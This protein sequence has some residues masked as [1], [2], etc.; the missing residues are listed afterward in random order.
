MTETAKSRHGIYL[1]TDVARCN[2]KIYS[3]G[4]HACPCRD[5]CLRFVSPVK[6]GFEQQQ[7]WVF[8]C[9]GELS[10]DCPEMI[11]VVP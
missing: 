5:N 2:G 6:P 10:D 8:V 11:S 1:P 9:G 7:R 4:V 3:K